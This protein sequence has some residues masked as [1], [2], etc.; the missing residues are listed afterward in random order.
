MA[1]QAK[2]IGAIGTRRPEIKNFDQA[3]TQAVTSVTSFTGPILLNAIGGGTTRTTRLGSQITMTSLEIR[4]SW[5]ATSQANKQPLRFVVVYDHSPNG[6]QPTATDVFSGNNENA[7]MNIG[8]SD[9]F[10][11][12][13]DRYLDNDAGYATTGAQ[14]QMMKYHRKLPNLIQKYQ[15]SNG[16][17]IADIT[18]GAIWMWF[19]LGGQIPGAVD[20][21]WQTRIRFVDA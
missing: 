21:E 7:F 16:A 13:L 18:T 15:N 8:N 5:Q 4:L 9:R 14:A 19:A 1:R 3:A 12:L 17:N 6:T 10:L 2:L 11:V 20:T